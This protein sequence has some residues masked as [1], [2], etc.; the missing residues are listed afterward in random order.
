VFVVASA[1]AIGQVGPHEA[2]IAS[3]ANNGLWK[4]DRLVSD[5]RS[6]ARLL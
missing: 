6:A 5:W 2:G 3:A 4:A 1:T